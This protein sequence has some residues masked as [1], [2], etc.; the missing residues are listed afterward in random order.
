VDDHTEVTQRSGATTGAYQDVSE[1]LVESNFI[2]Y[3]RTERMQNQT[4]DFRIVFNDLEPLAYSHALVVLNKNQIIRKLIKYL[5]FSPVE[6]R[7]G[8]ADDKEDQP[9]KAQES[10]E[11]NIEDLIY[12]QEAP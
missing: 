5:R 12:K 7:D 11:E 10:S 6:V 8:L 4:I 1:G 2:Q 3:L 9:D